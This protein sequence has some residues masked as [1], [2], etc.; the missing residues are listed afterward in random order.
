MSPAPT[1]LESSSGTAREAILEAA[2][3]EFAERGYEGVRLEHVA[4]RAG[5]NRALIYR[6]FGDREGLFHAALREQF[7][8]RAQ[9]LDRVPD[10]LGE[11]LSWWTSATLDD[12]TF[13]RMILRESLDYGGGEPIESAGRTQYYR[14]QLE[15][16]ENLRRRGVVDGAFDKELLFL[17]LLSVVI[18]PAIM[19][20]VV[21]L[22]TGQE[23][24]SDAFLE[25]W[26]RFLESFAEA[27]GPREGGET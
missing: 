11:I 21:H 19:P 22:V 27:L 4:Q 23:A 5:F 7:A 25:R 12:P 20:Q 15:M 2:I 14:R 24:G 9:L 17:A 18:L 13:I 6:Y 26:G 8:R 3:K 16:L 10:N 1:H